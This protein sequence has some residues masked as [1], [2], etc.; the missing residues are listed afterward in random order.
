MFDVTIEGLDELI[1]AAH[2]ADSKLRD[3]VAMATQ[4]AASDGVKAEQGSHP[5]T[6]RTYQLTET[7]RATK[8]ESVSDGVQSEMVWRKFYASFVT[9]VSGGRFDYRP[10]AER[11]ARASLKKYVTEAAQ[12][13]ADKLNGR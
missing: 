4:A 7:A 8:P 1:A 2:A 11:A 12:R 6:D 9:T 13:F 10:V 3:D 5:Y